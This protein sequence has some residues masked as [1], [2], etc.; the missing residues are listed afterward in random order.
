MLTGED[1]V[2]SWVMYLA[3][4]V[5]LLVVWWFITRP[6]GIKVVRDI[7]RLTAA[8]FLLV[9]FPVL[10]Q[11]QFWAPALGMSLLE[12][13]FGQSQGFN[14]AGVPVL[15]VWTFVIAFY[16]L[17]DTLWQRYRQRSLTARQE[18]QE[19]M[20]EHD[21]MVAESE[22][23]SETAPSMDKSPANDSL[24]N[25]LPENNLPENKPA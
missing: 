7:L 8:T 12:A 20:E 17:V 4:A 16:L 25:S 1:Y 2:T 22:M 11:E 14:R 24:A 18:H 13:V 6:I 15:I 3:G 5:G 21:E 23:V 19:L 10:N 9:P